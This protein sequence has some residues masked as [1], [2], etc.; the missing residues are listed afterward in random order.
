MTVKELNEI[1]NGKEK[2]YLFYDD[3]S[4]TLEREN[5]LSLLAFGDYVI[6]TIHAQEEESIIVYLKTE[7]KPIK[8]G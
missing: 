8:K 1:T 6:D 3:E 2:I 4:I 5:P 7:T